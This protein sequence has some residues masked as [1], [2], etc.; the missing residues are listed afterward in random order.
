MTIGA[1]RTVLTI[2]LTMV[3]ILILG[4][5]GVLA[6]AY[7]GTVDVAATNH[8]SA[9][10]SWFLSTARDHAIHA[11]AVGIA[12]PS[13]DGPRML[14]M[15]ADHYK[16]MCVGCHGAPGVEAGEAAQGLDP[17]PPILYQGPPMTKEDAAET[18]WV[19]KHGIQMTGMPAFGKTHDDDKLWAI[20]A[21][22]KRLNG[23]SSEEYRKATA[24]Q[25]ETESAGAPTADEHVG[26]QGGGHEHSDG[27][28]PPVQR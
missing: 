19:V 25:V 21:F 13:L 10:T 8:P 22:M 4:V 12:V 18:F 1:K 24:T 14:Q 7:S 26:Q 20:V 16:E 2:L 9:L 17:P 11:R 28:S 6:V 23:M 3:W 15:G 5:A 27:A